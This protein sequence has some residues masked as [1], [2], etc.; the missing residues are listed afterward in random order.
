MSFSSRRRNY[1]LTPHRRDGLI[2]WYVDSPD[3]TFHALTCNKL[4][5][6]LYI[7]CIGSLDLFLSYVLF[8]R[9]KSM[10]QHSFVLDALETTAADTFSHFEVLIDE[11]RRLDNQ[12]LSLRSYDCIVDVAHPMNATNTTIPNHH[13]PSHQKQQQSRLQQL[14]PTIGSF[15]TPLPLREAFEIY[16]EKHRLVRVCMSGHFIFCISIS[17]CILIFSCSL[18]TNLMQ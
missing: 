18:L 11:H 13:N 3:T 15:H 17:S 14:V 2:E 10:L 6:Y 5:V 9:M 1:L 16:N 8:R 4:N 12:Q 7:H